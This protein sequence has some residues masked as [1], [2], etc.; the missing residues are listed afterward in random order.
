MSEARSAETVTFFIK[1]AS[2][3]LGFDG[4]FL[5]TKQ[6]RKSGLFVAHCCRLI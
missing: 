1:S 6:S 2:N 4:K 3:I 5:N